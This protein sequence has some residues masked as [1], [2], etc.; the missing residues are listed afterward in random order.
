VSMSDSAGDAFARYAASALT[1]RVSL[2]SL[3]TAAL[4]AVTRPARAAG[5]AGKKANKKCRRQGA[6]CRDTFLENCAAS[7]DPDGCREAVDRC[8]ELLGKC[9]AGAF[10]ECLL[11]LPEAP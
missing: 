9:R 10:L 6:E 11:P 8:C 3:G 5:K 4:V 1:R 2:G 7:P